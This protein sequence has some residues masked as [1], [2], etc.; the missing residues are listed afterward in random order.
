M[1][2]LLYSIIMGVV[3]VVIEIVRNG[4]TFENLL[5]VVGSVAILSGVYY[6]LYF[7]SK[8]K[9]VGGGDWI[10]CLAIGLVLGDWRLA[11][12]ELFLANFIGAIVMLPLKQ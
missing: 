1:S 8:E 10:L 3:Y 9:L 11:L 7:F 12:I 2:M 6:L 4:F 5:Q